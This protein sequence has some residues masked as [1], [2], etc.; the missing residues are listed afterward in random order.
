MYSLNCIWMEYGVWYFFVQCCLLDLFILLWVTVV[1][2]L[3]LSSI[4]L[5]DYTTILK[6]IYEN[7]F[8]HVCF[9]GIWC[10]SHLEILWIMHLC[11]SFVVNLMDIDLIFIRYPHIK[12]IGP[13]VVSIFKVKIIQNSLLL[14]RA[15]VYENSSCCP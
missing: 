3:L 11:S 8:F 15:G 1:K 5:C 9:L 4:P 14:E 12:L 10:V 13:Q 6:N 7:L 2:F